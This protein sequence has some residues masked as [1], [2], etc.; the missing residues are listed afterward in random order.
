VLVGGGVVYN[1]FASLKSDWGLLGGK[2]KHSL[3]LSLSL[4][5]IA[6]PLKPFNKNHSINRSFWCGAQIASIKIVY[7]ITTNDEKG[8]NPKP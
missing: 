5:S 7:F 2:K 8:S 3:S 6:S 4:S 1:C